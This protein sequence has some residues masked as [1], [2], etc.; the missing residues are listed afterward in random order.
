MLV[1]K[2][3]EETIHMFFLSYFININFCAFMYLL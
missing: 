3:E 1:V 2:E